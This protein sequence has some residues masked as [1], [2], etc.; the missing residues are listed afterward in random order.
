MTSTS[1][2]VKFQNNFGVG[3]ETEIIVHYRQRKLINAVTLTRCL[4]KIIR[5]RQRLSGVVGPKTL[6]MISV[7]S[8]WAHLCSSGQTRMYR[9]R[10]LHQRGLDC[11]KL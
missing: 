5:I 7:G 9:S 6:T 2:F 3:T 11:A 8:C 10:Q 4:K 1:G